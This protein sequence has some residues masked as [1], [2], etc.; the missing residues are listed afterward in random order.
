MEDNRPTKQ[1]LKYHPTGRYGALLKDLRDN[2]HAET[3]TGPLMAQ[4]LDWLMMMM[5]HVQQQQQHVFTSLLLPR[6][7]LMT[8]R[9]QDRRIRLLRDASST[10]EAIAELSLVIVR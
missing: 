3:E 6:V 2:V 1:I 5:I 7:K 9:A 10:I 8:S 4:L